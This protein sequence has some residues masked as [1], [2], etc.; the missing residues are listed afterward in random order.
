MPIDYL[1]DFPVARVWVGD[2]IPAGGVL[3]LG[4]SWYG[5][6]EGDLNFDD[7]YI[8]AYLAGAV[9]D[10]MYSKIAYAICDSK[11]SSSK[12]AFWQ[13]VAFTNFVQCVGPTLG[14][15]PTD[16]MYRAG[17]LRLEAI[18]AAL[19]PAS[20]WI[21]GEEQAKWSRPVVD[22]AGIVSEVCPHPSRRGVTTAMLRESWSRLGAK[23][24]EDPPSSL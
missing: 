7:G 8:R 5:T 22:S 3:V 20:V 1:R 6:Y 14:H 2:S 21:L 15:R 19:G 4:E 16:E 11:A 17:Q 10:R 24:P 9:I 23:L 18:L 12:S 13:R